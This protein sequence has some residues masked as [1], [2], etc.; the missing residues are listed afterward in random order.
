MTLFPIP[1]SLVAAVAIAVGWPGAVLWGVAA[2]AFFGTAML[3]VGALIT[4][5]K[6]VL[7]PYVGDDLTR[8]G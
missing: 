5:A 8:I 3:G 2:S 1:L 7:E 4:K 6:P